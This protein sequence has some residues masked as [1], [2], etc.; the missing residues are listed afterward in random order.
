MVL[1]PQ[2]QQ[3]LLVHR[4]LA[5]YTHCLFGC[6]V[7][8]KCIY[9]QMFSIK[10]WRSGE[11]FHVFSVVFQASTGKKLWEKK[12]VKFNG[13]RK[14]DAKHS[15]IVLTL[16]VRRAMVAERTKAQLFDRIAQM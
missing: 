14:S 9:R 12:H 10:S 13:T 2:Q 6:T 16:S 8:K 3:H 4:G 11:I 1:V 7:L 5:T 15:I